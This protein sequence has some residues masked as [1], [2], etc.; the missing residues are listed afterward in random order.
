MRA[1]PKLRAGDELRV[2]AL[3]RSLGGVMQP[4]GFTEADVQ[5]AVQ[6]LESLGLRVTFGQWVRE[7]NEHLTA[8]PEH[9][10]ADL[11][12]AF[13][14]PAVKAILA[15]TGGIGAIQLLDRLDYELIAGHPKILCGYSDIAYFNNALA[16]RA[17][18]ST[19]YGP[20]FTTFMMRQ[21][22]DFIRERFRAALF[23]EGPRLLQPAGEWSDDA[24]HQDQENRN[25]HPNEGYWPIQSGTAAGTILGGSYWCLNQL[26]GS[27]YFPS[28]QDSL[29][30]LE[31]PAQGKATLM[32]LDSGLRA[33]TFQPGFSGVRGLV[34]GRYA[35]SGGVTRE[36]LTALL[37]HISA[38]NHLPIVANADFGHTTPMVTLAIGGQGRIA[39]T[40]QQAT[41]EI[42]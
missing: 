29:L 28:L 31:H 3:S 37:Q 36:N 12:A 40:N 19:Y 7:C 21:G 14:D 5:F 6:R 13:A 4:G 34:L 30:F 20:N 41:I 33:L 22:A 10:L 26:Q 27:P 1:P 38:L 17:G 15:V 18:V 9:R 39:V 23:D 25:F 35:R 16:A 42:L 11:Q 8:S 2:L 24:W 32:A